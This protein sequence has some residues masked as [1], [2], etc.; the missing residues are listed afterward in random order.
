MKEIMDSNQINYTRADGET[1]SNDKKKIKYV[2]AKMATSNKFNMN[3]K[4]WS[5]YVNK[6]QCG[7]CKYYGHLAPDCPGE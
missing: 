1:K 7:K 6:M 5:E 3:E 4:K 2:N